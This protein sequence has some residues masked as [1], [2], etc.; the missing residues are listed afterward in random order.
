[1]S[2]TGNVVVV[3]VIV[4]VVVVA[5]SRY[6]GLCR[7]V[8]SASSVLERP[9]LLDVCFIAPPNVRNLGQS[10]QVPYFD[11]LRLSNCLSCRTEAAWRT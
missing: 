11:I 5:I 1:M 2:K 7:E 6:L 4:V 9:Y 8:I 3:V 10:R